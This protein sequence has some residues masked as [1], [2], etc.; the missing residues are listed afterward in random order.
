M[1]TEKEIAIAQ[2]MLTSL[3]REHNAVK[4]I[5]EEVTV[6]E[7]LGILEKDGLTSQYWLKVEIEKKDKIVKIQQALATIENLNGF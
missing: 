7:K 2:N 6:K 5:I 1:L 4:S 3:V